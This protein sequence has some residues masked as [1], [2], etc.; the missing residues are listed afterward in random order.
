MK[1]FLKELARWWDD[2]VTTAVFAALGATVILAGIDRA[3]RNGDN[4]HERI[5]DFEQKYKQ[6]VGWLTARLELSA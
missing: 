1:D 5:D 4:A 6:E 3:N 2:P